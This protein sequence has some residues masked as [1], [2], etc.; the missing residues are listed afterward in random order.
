[1]IRKGPGDG[2]FFLHVSNA[3]EVMRAGC[4]GFGYKIIIFKSL[5][6]IILQCMLMRGYF[7]PNLVYNQSK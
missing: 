6:S 2:V 1:M 5:V 4:G 7:A 3:I